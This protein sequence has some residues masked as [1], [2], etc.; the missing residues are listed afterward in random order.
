MKTDQE[1]LKDFCR[2]VRG[3]KSEA[4][5]SISALYNCNGKSYLDW[6]LRVC[7][8]QLPDNYYVGHEK[9]GTLD[10]EL[11]WCIDRYGDCVSGV[12]SKLMADFEELKANLLASVKK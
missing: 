8:S 4:G 10:G 11:R 3:E 7:R 6:L 5:I 2:F 9:F 1:T 12:H